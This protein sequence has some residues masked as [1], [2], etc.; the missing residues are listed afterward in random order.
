LDAVNL[1]ETNL[2]FCVNT[3]SECGGPFSSPICH[4]ELFHHR[5]NQGACDPSEMGED[6]WQWKQSG[7][8]AMSYRLSYYTGVF[9]AHEES[10][11]YSYRRIGNNWRVRRAALEV[12]VDAE[13]TYDDCIGG[14]GGDGDDKSCNNCRKKRVRVS[15]EKG[16]DFQGDRTY[17]AHC[18]DYVTGTFEKNRNGINLTDN[19]SL[20]GFECCE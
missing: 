20:V 10:K 18:D 16:I 4:N 9:R 5:L 17:L 19:V 11:I 3:L 2:N 15:T 13:R 6:N 1:K 14:P 7:N 12:S 8:Q